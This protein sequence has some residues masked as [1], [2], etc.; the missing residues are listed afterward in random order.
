MPVFLW[1]AEP[2]VLQK[3]PATEYR[4]QVD[5]AARLV[6]AAPRAAIQYDYVVTA[7]VRLLLFWVSRDDV[8]QGYIRIGT[9]PDDPSMEVVQLLM[10]SD[11]AKAPLSTNNWG[12]V[13][14][15]WRP[16]DSSGAFFAFMKAPKDDS[17]ATAKDEVAREK[18]KGRYQYQ[19]VISRVLKDRLVSMTVPISSATDFTLHQLPLAQQM[20]LEQLKTASRL[21]RTMEVSAA[22]GCASACGFLF[23]V[24]D[25]IAAAPSGR[26]APIHSCY[27]YLS[28][29]YRLSILSLEPLRELKVSLKMR[30]ASNRL[31]RTYGNLSRAEFRVVNL[32][33]GN[34]TDFKMIFGTTGA[35]KGIPI[36]AEFQPNWWFRVT[37][38]L[39]PGIIPGPPVK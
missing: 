30:G 8:G 35:L 36:Q 16:S 18:E 33:T 23:A 28:W 2:N 26:R 7:A 10:G 9:H 34:P 39:N 11:P 31:E 4:R 24:R 21:P 37:I 13:T 19:G 3:E 25:L 20:V 6:S 32:K 15:I 14:E 27:S 1:S 22:N 12:A 17:M 38:N 29:S 5:E